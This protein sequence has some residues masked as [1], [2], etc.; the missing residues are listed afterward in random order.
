M[1]QR[2]MGERRH[3]ST[4]LN[5]GTRLRWVVNFTPLS[6]YLWKNSP[7]YPLYRR[8]DGPHIQSGCNEE[9]S[10]FPIQGIEPQ[11]PACPNLWPRHYT[12]W[13]I[14]AWNTVTCRWMKYYTVCHLWLRH[15]ATSR[16][17]AVSI[18]DEVTGFS[19]WPNHSSCTMTLELTQPLTEMST[20]N[21]PGRRRVRL[22]TPPL[23]VSWLSR[24]CGSLDVWQP[25][26]PPWPVAGVAFSIMKNVFCNC[27]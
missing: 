23:S 3:S 8:S 24:K 26:G 20:K 5:L 19:S 13:A 16:K 21:L 12:N 10:I 7:Q 1:P 25:Y 27:Q 11:L 2:C 9:K 4:I 22:T 14:L 6:L 15:C 18:P 17:V